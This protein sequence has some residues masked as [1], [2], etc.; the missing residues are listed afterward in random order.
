MTSE[1]VQRKLQ[2]I[3]RTLVVCAVVIALSGVLL[4]QYK[5][6][7]LAGILLA[8]GAAA[9]FT[10]A[11]QHA[12]DLIARWDSYHRISGHHEKVRR[13]GQ[14]LADCWQL[15]FVLGPLIIGFVALWH[16]IRAFLPPS[17]VVK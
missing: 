1:Y 13:I 7:Y 10:Y 17:G 8:V 11:C 16:S 12:L 4:G 2:L 6:P 3:W 14:L 9:A 15:M 5:H